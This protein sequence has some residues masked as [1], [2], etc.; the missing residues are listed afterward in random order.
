VLPIV[1][2]LRNGE[3][4]S[5]ARL[6]VTVQNEVEAGLA[7]GAGIKDVEAGSAGEAAGL[8]PGDVVLKVDDEIIASVDALV[9][10]IRGYRP[11]D[12]VTLT[13]LRDGETLTMD[14]TLDSDVEGSDS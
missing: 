6:G 8:Q 13:V 4:P 3:T 9:A 12:E 10:T 11:G 14:A 1:G 5:H 2:Q 7:I